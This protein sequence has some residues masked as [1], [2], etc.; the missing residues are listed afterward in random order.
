[1]IQNTLRSCPGCIGC[2]LS[3]EL[4]SRAVPIRGYLAILTQLG[5]RTALHVALPPRP[6][7]GPD[8]ID[9]ESSDDGVLLPAHKEQVGM[10]STHATTLPHTGAT[11]T[12]RRARCPW[13][14]TLSPSQA[15]CATQT[16]RN[17]PILWQQ[18]SNS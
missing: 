16:S 3:Q 2:D 9:N 15:Y 4:P 7:G 14:T 1:M 5:A 18:P 10:P 11:K 12:L 13:D 6:A 8:L 17:V